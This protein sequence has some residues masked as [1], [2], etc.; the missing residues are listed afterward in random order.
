MLPQ[1]TACQW[2]PHQKL[3]CGRASSPAHYG[4]LDRRSDADNATERKIKRVRRAT[5]P[6]PTLGLTLRVRSV[7][8]SVAYLVALA[9]GEQ[10][11]L[12]V[13]VA[14]GLAGAA[15]PQVEGEG[16]QRP[17][18]GEAADPPPLV[19]LPICT[20]GASANRGQR[21]RVQSVQI[22]QGQELRHHKI[23]VYNRQAPIAASRPVIICTW[24]QYPLWHA[25]VR[26]TTRRP[27]SPGHRTGAWTQGATTRRSPRDRG[28]SGGCGG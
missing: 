4:P 16:E 18:Q 20:T 1:Y 17:R 3:Y 2:S 26:Y 10:I 24:E 22:Q 14:A 8:G 6:R 25:L 28:W 9:G 27:A 13:V 21:R 12:R 11:A 7:Q 5:F 23:T 19:L 15:L